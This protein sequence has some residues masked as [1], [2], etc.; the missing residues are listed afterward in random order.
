MIC[1]AV[2]AAAASGA[3]VCPPVGDCVIDSPVS[4]FDTVFVRGNLLINSSSVG[5]NQPLIKLVSSATAFLNVSGQV[6]IVGSVLRVSSI[7]FDAT[8]A[9]YNVAGLRVIYSR[10]PVRGAFASVQVVDE[11]FSECRRIAATQVKFADGL[12]LEITS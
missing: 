8:K 4:V 3:S 5:W 12:G 11:G 1:L 9:L 7:D 2:F 6:E 10:F